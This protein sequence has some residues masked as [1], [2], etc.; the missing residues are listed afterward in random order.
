MKNVACHV[1]FLL[2]ITLPSFTQKIA[3]LVKKKKN[4]Q[5]KV[6][7]KLFLVLLSTCKLIIQMH[8]KEKLYRAAAHDI[9]GACALRVLFL[10]GSVPKKSCALCIASLCEIAGDSASPS[11]FLF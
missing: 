1:Y 11:A 3:L 6:E 8:I 4:F 9:T 2:C 10:Q 7:V 5:V